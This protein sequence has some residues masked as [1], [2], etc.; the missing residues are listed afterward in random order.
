MS[1]GVGEGLVPAHAR[2]A[3]AQTPRMLIAQG[4]RQGRADRL[5]FPTGAAM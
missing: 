1:E 5:E 3:G 2:A 4:C